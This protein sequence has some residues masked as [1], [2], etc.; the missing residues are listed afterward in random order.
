[1]LRNSEL[2]AML[3]MD[4]GVEPKEKLRAME[5]LREFHRSYRALETFDEKQFE[6]MSADSSYAASIRL[7]G[8]SGMRGVY[9]EDASWADD[10]VD[11]FASKGLISPELTYFFGRAV[12]RTLKKN[13]CNA[14][15]AGQD[16]RPSSEMLSKFMLQGLLDEGLEVKYVGIC[17]TPAINIFGGSAGII[18]TASHSNIS[19]NGIKSFFKGIPITHKMERTIEKYLVKLQML[20]KQGKGL[21][22]DVK[23]PGSLLFARDEVFRTYEDKM[24]RILLKENLLIQNN[25]TEEVKGALGGNWM[26]VDLAFGAGAAVRGTSGCADKLSPQLNILLNTGAVLVGYASEIAPFETNDAVGAGY[27]YGEYRKRIDETFAKERSRRI[28]KAEVRERFLREAVGREY[29]VEMSRRELEAFAAGSY[30]YGKGE[31]EIDSLL[32]EEQD[33]Y[34]IRMPVRDNA[35][36]RTVYFPAGYEFRL[37]ELK[38]VTESAGDGHHAIYDIDSESNVEKRVLLEKEL[39]ELKQLPSLSI[40]C[41]GDRFLA[42]SPALLDAPVPFLS[43]DTAIALFAKYKPDWI[44]KIV[45]TVESGMSVEKFL[46]AQNI[47][48]RTVT[49][50]D[51]AIADYIKDP[52]RIKTDGQDH[53]MIAGGEPSGHMIFARLNESTDEMEL[54]DDPILTH[55]LIASIMRERNASFQELIDAVEREMGEEVPTIRKPEAYARDVDHDGLSFAEKKLLELRKTRGDRILLTDYA[56]H[57]I[58]AVM[59]MFGKAYSKVFYNGAEHNVKIDSLYQTLANGEYRL[60]KSLQML[61]IGDI[62]F[63]GFPGVLTVEIQLTDKSWAGPVDFNLSFLIN[64]NDGLLHRVGKYIGRN[65]GTSPKHAGYVGIWT[66]DYRGRTA[67]VKEIENAGSE[68]KKNVVK[69]TEDYIRHTRSK[70]AS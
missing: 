46:E 58:P 24:S 48:C 53:H 45:I 69:L 2:D 44:R 1:M 27:I 18:I 70:T 21:A 23:S 12:A 16:V 20:K 52:E 10:C 19:Y 4:Y 29:E 37:P 43:G 14:A 67:S 57:L 33:D 26:A 65:S 59:D 13:G 30:G 42:V 3:M 61:R 9:T 60:K 41:D 54:L 66:D 49:V 55:L 11:A 34:I 56:L 47:E 36:N 22:A 5:K 32:T 7:F 39:G 40:D 51:R 15:Y 62:E 25:E 50:G 28:E 35:V 38:A 64:G 31:M 8:T 6:N 63:R 17:T 68:L